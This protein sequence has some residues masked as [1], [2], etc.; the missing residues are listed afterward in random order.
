M[1]ERTLL[2]QQCSDIRIGGNVPQAYM[3]QIAA[4]YKSG[5]RFWADTANYQY[6]RVSNK[7]LGEE[8]SNE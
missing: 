3:E 8:N 1:Q 6:Y 7:P 2:T 4:R 5:I